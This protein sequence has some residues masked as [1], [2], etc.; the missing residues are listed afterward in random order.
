MRCAVP[1]VL[2]LPALGL[3]A[4]CGQQGMPAATPDAAL[5]AQDPVIARALHDPLLTDPDL[6]S[7]NEANAAI[8]FPDSA[9]LPVLGPDPDEAKRTR[10][11]MRL[12]LLAGGPIPPL[13]AAGAAAGP[14][15]GPRSKGGELLAA[16]GAP[17]DC[18]GALAEDF[19]RAADLP[20]P[21]AMP[22]R[23]MLVQAGG[24]DKAGCKVVIL[25]YLSP[26]PRDELLQYHHT[27]ALRAGLAPARSRDAISAGG[28]GAE[29][30]VV[31]VR[32]AP[33]GLSGVTLVYRA[34]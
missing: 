28:K 8:G 22:P 15:L 9:A 5:I 33:G 21:A 20:P 23:T 7:R 29:R 32:A 30:L 2:L 19:A 6:A 16:V 25:R 34:E 12:E 31:H 18:A 26:V 13:P 4:A 3:A 1:H 10:E 24:A 17:A 27:R 14:V 11:A